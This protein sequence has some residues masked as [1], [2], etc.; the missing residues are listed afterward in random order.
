MIPDISVVCPC[1]NEEANASAIAA[2]VIQQLE[3]CDVTW[4]LVFI[5]N[6][7]S[8]RTVEII[9]EL[10]ARDPRIKL[11]VNSRNFGQMR[12]PTYGVYQARGRAVIAIVADFQD[13]PELIPDF[14]RRWRAGADIV[15]GTRAAEKAGLRQTLIR[16]LGYRVLRAVGD[17][18]IIPG[19]TG[20]GLY[21]RRVI[22]LLS[23][24]DEPEPFFR[25][26]LV[27]SGFRIE[28]VPH[29]RAAR[30]RGASSNNFARLYSF[31]LSG[32]AGSARGI[33]RVPVALA[34]GSGAITGVLVLVALL[35]TLLGRGAAAW[36][37]AALVQA[38][39]S[40]LLLFIGL[41]GDQ[42]RLTAERTRR[43]PLVIERERINFDRD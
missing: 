16:K 35:A 25:G 31:A 30:L 27:E 11:I 38:N 15:L 26:M 6:A 12:S 33:L 3:L 20:F 29:A 10:C 5:D 14:V 17:Y 8:D 42:V 21:S 37:I 24:I 32:L 36:W 39:A 18:P 4:E 2:A 43:T 40:V 22:D 1:F 23:A 19:A 13:P 34:I 28:T 41:M 9:R 7:S